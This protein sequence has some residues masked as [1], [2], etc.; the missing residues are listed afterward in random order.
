MSEHNIVEEFVAVLRKAPKVA[1]FSHVSPDGDCLGSMLAIGLALEKMGKEVSFY[2]PDPVPSNLVFLPGSS[3]IRRQ[4]PSPQPETLLFVDC[5]DLGRVNLSISDITDL[6]TVLNLDH[7]ISN[8]YFGR[9]NWVDS[10]A[11]AVGELALTLINRLG[12][13]IDSD[14]AA[15]LYTAI[16]T[17]SGCFQYSNTTAQTHRLSADLMDKGINISDIHH[18]IFDQKP[19]S[20]IRL[21]QYALN[22]LEMCAEG[23]LA[24]MTLSTEDFHK[25]GAEQE[26]SEGLVNHARS[27]AGVEVAVLL[28]E[29]GPQEIKGGLRSN[30]W[31]NVN[32]IAAQFGGGGHNR[33]A[34]FTFRGTLAEAKQRIITAIE[35][36][37]RL[38]RNH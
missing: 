22:G 18:R 1:L 8:Q 17:D 4:L 2:N 24:L 29:V 28:K 23:Q 14:I 31:L 12:V 11:S 7:H 37:L 36:A 6:S 13:E 15:N 19:L 26:L 25:S 35:E 21:L 10:Q 38:G 34:G 20:Q 3:R 16:V 9:V 5:T 27:I 32:E 30:L 33:A